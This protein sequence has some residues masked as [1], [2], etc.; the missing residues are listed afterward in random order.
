MTL[1]REESVVRKTTRAQTILESGHIEVHTLY[2][3][4]QTKLGLQQTIQRVAGL[5]MLFDPE[6]DGAIL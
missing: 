1:T 4:K 5:C 3:H 2:A 6:R